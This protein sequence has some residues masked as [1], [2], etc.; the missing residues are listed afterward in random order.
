MTSKTLISATALSTPRTTTEVRKAG[1]YSLRH[2]LPVLIFALLAM[3]GSAFSWMAY[4]EVE[5]ALR[6][7]GGERINVAGGQIADLL[8]QS[9]MARLAEARRLAGDSAVQQ[10]ALAKRQGLAEEVPEVLQ[11]FASRNPLT[12]V[13]ISDGS[14]RPFPPL[15]QGSGGPNTRSPSDTGDVALG[16]GPLRSDGGHVWYSATV[17]IPFSAERKAPPMSLT[18]QRVLGSNQAGALI[19]RL[20]GSGA[21]LTFGNA[22]GDTWTDLSKPVAAPPVSAPGS[23]TTYVTSAGESR[24]GVAK[25]IAGTPWL[26]WAEV[27]ERSVL[28]PATALLTRMVPITLVFTLL[29]AFA[30]YTLSGRV[31]RPLEQLADATE[32]IAGG[33]YT[34]RVTVTGGNEV[35]RLGAAFNLMATQV[36]ESHDVLEARVQSRTRELELA[37]EELDQFFS[38]SLDLLCISGMDGTFK[39]VNPAWEQVLGWSV[40]DSDVHAVPGAGASGR[41]GV[42]DS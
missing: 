28:G 27:S 40:A 38:L 17:S 12:T 2:R 15:V 3:L 22:T 33:D 8:G 39:R 29:G 42:D 32:A 19:E 7:S 18:I 4:V 13:W 35:A 34:R 37:R 1:G 30:V 6:V 23:P 16:I 36:A 25:P 14:G 41:P 10:S 5:R 24:I 9:A 21:T 11:T 20:I 31:A 26:L